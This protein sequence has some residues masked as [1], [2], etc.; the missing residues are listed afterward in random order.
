M[1]QKN[2][3]YIYILNKVNSCFKIINKEK[4]FL[5]LYREIHNHPSFF[6]ISQS[7]KKKK[8]WLCR[9][10]WWWPQWWWLWQYFML[11][12]FF[13]YLAC[14]FEL[15]LLPITTGKEQCYIPC[16]DQPIQ[17]IS[18]C[19]VTITNTPRDPLP[20]QLSPICTDLKAVTE[21]ASV[22]FITHKPQ[23]RHVNRCHAQM[24]CLK[25]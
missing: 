11:R 6:P 19:R 2:I 9:V 23:K 15:Q 21:L 12:L 7:K 1:K 25:V 5:N 13:P 16:Y 14:H 4:L 20:F 18:Y 3:I 22:I 10:Q 24:K 17:T 8:T